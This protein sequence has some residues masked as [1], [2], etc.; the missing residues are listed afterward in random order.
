MKNETRITLILAALIVWGAR[1]F[2]NPSYFQNNLMFIG[3]VILI[4][5]F[6][7]YELVL[8]FKE[9]SILKK[10]GNDS[11]TFAQEVNFY[12]YFLV[13]LIIIYIFYISI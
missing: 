3:F 2:L 9:R 13:L 11:Q 12:S 6:M 5:G 10:N 1:K 7:L 4:I 8:R